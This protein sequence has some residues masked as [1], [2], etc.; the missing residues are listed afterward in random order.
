MFGEMHRMTFVLAVPLLQMVS[1]GGLLQ[2]SMQ[3]SRRAFYL[4]HNLEKGEASEQL[5]GKLEEASF[6]LVDLLLTIMS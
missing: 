6:V 5:D 4:I 2:K 1:T 3:L